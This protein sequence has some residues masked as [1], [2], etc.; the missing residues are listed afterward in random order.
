MSES[1]GTRRT[2]IRPGYPA[3]MRYQPL[4]HSGLMVSV[5]GLG[6]NNFGR[7]LEVEASRPV[8][9]GALD[10]GINLI[11]TSDSYGSQPGA[12]ETIIGSVLAANGRR[13]DV[14]IATKFGSDLSGSNGLD[15]G[16][17]ASRRYI[18]RAVEASLRRLQTDYIDLYQLHFPDGITPLA[19]TLSAL[20]DLVVAGK[21]RYI[22]ASNLAAWQVA[23]ADWIAR[24]L[25]IS[26]FISAQNHYSLLVREI[27]A[28]LVPCCVAHSV[29]VIPYFPLANGM[30]TGKWRRGE[31]PPAGSRLAEQRARSAV[32]SN[33]RAFDVV[34][35]LQS[36]ADEAG[37][38]LVSVAI[39][40]LAAQ[41]A[42]GSVIAGATSV[43]QVQANAA[44]S[45][46]VPTAEQLR[47]IDE[48]APPGR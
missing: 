15:L 11:D 23:E 13:D 37:V 19:E 41:P 39:G 34:E 31:E 33:E 28:E 12:S 27:E 22:G 7:R 36:V 14:V 29:S 2:V 44:A 30:L 17:R 3:L 5:V 16:A 6:A 40:A 4:G 8:I 20:N 42:V 9:E 45:D 26:R 10:A 46:F 43:E 48:I 18:M 24:D 25:G 38:P 1:R 32:T 35:G 21:I 47:A